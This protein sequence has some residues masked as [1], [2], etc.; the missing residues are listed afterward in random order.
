MSKINV[1]KFFVLTA[2]FLLLGASSVYAASDY[3]FDTP[4][5][6][7]FNYIEESVKDTNKIMDMEFTVVDDDNVQD[8]IKQNIDI[9]KFNPFRLSFRDGQYLYIVIGYGEQRTG[10]YGIQVNELY[11]SQDCIVIS[12]ELLSP[13]ED[14]SVT[15]NITYPYLVIRTSD[16]FLPVYYK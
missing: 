5:E 11:E 9:L 1:P 4:I 12:T 13:G 14:D 6:I 8:V 10:G 3:Y 2:V 15:M 16:L 7:N